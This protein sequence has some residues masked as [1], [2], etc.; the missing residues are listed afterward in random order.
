VKRLLRAGVV[1]WFL[2]GCQ[3]FVSVDESKEV[4]STAERCSDL[5]DNDEDGLLDCEE[6]TCARVPACRDVARPGFVRTLASTD[7]DVVWGMAM[8]AQDQL[9][10]TGVVAGDVKIGPQTY[11]GVDPG[12]GMLVTALDASGD[13]RWVDRQGGPGFDAGHAVAVDLDGNVWVTGEVESAAKFGDQAP[14]QPPHGLTD[15]FLAKYDQAG[16]LLWHTFLGGLGEDRGLALCLGGGGVV[17]VAGTYEERI[18]LGQADCRALGGADIFVARFSAS[19]ELLASTCFGS[20]GEDAA[21]GMVS[22]RSDNLVIVG[23]VS[24]TVDF[25]DVS[26]TGNSGEDVFVAKLDAALGYARWGKVFG[27]SGMDRGRQVLLHSLDEQLDESVVVVGHFDEQI[28]FGTGGPA[29]TTTGPLDRDAFVVKLDGT[30]G[31][32]VWS[33]RLGGAGTEAATGLAALGEDKLV[34]SGFFDGTSMHGDVPLHSYHPETRD[35]FVTELDGALGKVQAAWR[36]GGP[37]DDGGYLDYYGGSLV[38][39]T[40]AREILVCGTFERQIVLLPGMPTYNTQSCVG[41]V[42]CPTDVFLMSFVP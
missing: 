31:E 7:Q 17:A 27:G 1:G 19:G 13:V 20:T 32:G 4:E 25:G 28:D 34:V 6:T 2:C 41:D 30:D 9:V 16:K 3:L 21:Y 8:G 36:F 24:G 23:V 12:A 40:K 5:V 22:D 37:G 35:I 38:A 14:L 26:A 18:V 29:L 11:V 42:A 33:T 39:S 10:M 15:A